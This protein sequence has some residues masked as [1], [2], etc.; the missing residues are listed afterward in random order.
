M[1]EFGL[2]SMAMLKGLSPFPGFG[3][4]G[5][6]CGAVGGGLFV[7]GLYFGSDDP[8]D[9]R[10]TGAAMTAARDFISRFEAVLASTLCREI[11]ED[12]IFGRY[13]DARASREN[14]EA[15]QRE[16]GYAKCALPAGVGARLAAEII[17]ESMEGNRSR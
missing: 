5:S 9:Y 14:F 16:L 3:A 11:Q 1:E 10:A 12:M 6:V 4:T 17:I 8:T 13:M 15:F 7:L 2:G